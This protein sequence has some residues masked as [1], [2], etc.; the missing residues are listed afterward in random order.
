MFSVSLGMASLA[1][2]LLAVRSGYS[3]TEVGLLVAVSALTQMTTRLVLGRA[4]RV[5]GDWVLVVAAAALLAGSNALLALTAAAVPFT[6]AAAV[7]GVA[8]ACFWT[9]S[10]T[11]VV[12]GPGT[13]VGALAQVNFISSL[14]LLVGPTLAGIL[15][16]VS[17][18]TAFGVAAL[19]AVAAVVPALL[20][21]RLPPFQPPPDR[22]PGRIWRRPG[23]ATGCW[24]GASA[25]AWRGLLGSY[26][27]VALEAAR[28]PGTTTGALVSV[29]NAASV[30][31][32]VVVGRVRE[33][34]VRRSLVLG[35]LL[36]GLA[37][38]L[39]VPLAPLAWAAGIALALSG[40][41]AGALQTVGP[42]VA[43][44]AVHAE[45][46]GEAIAATGTFRAAALLGAPLA[47]AGTLAV[48]PLGAAMAGA[49]LAIAAPALLSGRV[50]WRAGAPTGRPVGA[51]TTP[52]NRRG[53]GP[54][55]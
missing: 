6:L 12:R 44:D 34:W 7:Q 38:G 13:A 14:G 28:Q 32:A 10:Q 48:A 2:P 8:R 16:E 31:G 4:M 53:G 20:L 15:A 23:V 1:M 54:F 45:E 30:V 26:V 27:P 42:A 50:P 5:V 33:R 52:S 40:L 36:A 21:D 11:H 9:G 3:V 55:R 51:P 18:Q 24:A 43:T 25:G 17:L 47:V 41:G 29:A 19:V 46:R 35:C 39:F 49:G 37:L 22:P